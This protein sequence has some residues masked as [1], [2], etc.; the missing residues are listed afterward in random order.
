[1]DRTLQKGDLVLIRDGFDRPP[2]YPYKGCGMFI[3]YGTVE[4]YGAEYKVAYVLIEGSIQAF[5]YPYW[6]I[7]K[8]INEDR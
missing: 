1:M 6:E 7:E 8:V 4:K 5:D 2:L 3:K